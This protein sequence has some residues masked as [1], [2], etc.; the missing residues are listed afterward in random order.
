MGRKVLWVRRLVVMIVR[1]R[2]IIRRF[3]IRHLVTITLAIQVRLRTISGQVIRPQAITILATKVRR[4]TTRGREI[5]PL[6]IGTPVQGNRRLAIIMVLEIRLLAII[7]DRGDRH[8][9]VTQ[10]TTMDRHR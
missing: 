8:L 4:R 6:A 9:V 2:I 5:R 10:E 7:P 3:T 1:R